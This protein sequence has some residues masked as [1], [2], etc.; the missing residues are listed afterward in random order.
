MSGR[1]HLCGYGTQ[2][3]TE[4]FAATNIFIRQ[5]VITVTI[6]EVFNAFTVLYIIHFNWYLSLLA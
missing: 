5:T 4:W 2:S 1:G 6:F 3:S